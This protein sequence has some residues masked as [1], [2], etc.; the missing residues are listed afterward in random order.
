MKTNELRRKISG[1]ALMLAMMIGIT[2][3]ASE[4]AQAQYRDKTVTVVM[5]IIVSGGAETTKG[6]TPSC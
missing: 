4:T 6:S 2:I 1:A 3:A 5:K